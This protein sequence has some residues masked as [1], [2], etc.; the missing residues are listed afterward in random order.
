MKKLLLLCTLSLGV[1]CLFAQ[2]KAIKT[3]KKDKDDAYDDIQYLEENHKDAAIGEIYMVM[4]DQSIQKAEETDSN[5]ETATN[6]INKV[7]NTKNISRKSSSKKRA[8]RKKVKRKRTLLKPKRKRKLK[9][10]PI[11]PRF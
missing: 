8:K 5:Q 1:G 6:D 2:D 3:I 7:S 9:N 10:R 4:P 11:C